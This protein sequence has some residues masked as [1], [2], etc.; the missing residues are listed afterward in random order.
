MAYS[1]HDTVRQDVLKIKVLGASG[2]EVGGHLCPAF[3]V[4]GKLLLDAGTVGVSLNI[5]EEKEIRYILLTHA[6]FDHIKGIPFLLDN[7][8][9]RGTHCSVT[10][11]GAREVI[12]DLRAY[13]LNDRIWPDFSRI[14]TPDA[15]VVRYA[16]LRPD[17]TVTVDGYRITAE[18]VSHTVCAFGY[19]LEDATGSVLA[20]TGDTGPTDLF[21]K[22]SN[23]FRVDCL[24]VETSFPN[25]MED[26]ALRSGHLTP[27]L[28]RRE[29][30]KMNRPPPKI[31]LIHAKPQY[32]PEIE[33]EIREL[34]RDDIRFL[35]AGEVLEI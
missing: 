19:I 34:G 17:V 6:H 12:E 13:I 20:Y 8:V 1:A 30:G 21:W 7:L 2:S 9:S 29:I 4:D 5:N 14:P 28:L 26:E 11:M 35:K 10:V 33:K 24:I 22:K 25:R 31:L 32:H 16:I 15:P 3:A 27:S 23:H 18:K